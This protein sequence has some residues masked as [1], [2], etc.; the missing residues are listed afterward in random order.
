MDLIRKGYVVVVL[1]LD[2][3]H[4][5]SILQREEIISR[6]KIHMILKENER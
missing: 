2:H 1:R 5:W 3:N 6:Y 4:G